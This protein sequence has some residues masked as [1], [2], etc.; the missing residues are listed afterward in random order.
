MNKYLIFY[1][2]ISLL[3]TLITGLS[4]RWAL[5]AAWKSAAVN[6][7]SARSWSFKPVAQKF[8][9]FFGQARSRRPSFRL[10]LTVKMSL[11]F[12][13]MIAVF[14]L[15]A[16]AAAYYAL[17][18]AITDHASKRAVAL[19]TNVGDAAAGQMLAKKTAGLQELVVK[20]ARGGEVAYLVVVDRKGKVLA[21]S[22]EN[23]PDG[24]KTEFAREGLEGLH[25][26]KQ[27][28][29]TFRGAVVYEARVPILEGRIGAVRAAIWK[30]AVDDEIKRAAIPLFSMILIAVV[31]GVAVA[32]CAARRLSQPIL[33]L[34]ES[35]DRISSGSLE[36]APFGVEASGEIGRLA[37]SVERM[38]SSLKAAMTRLGNDQPSSRKA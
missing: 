34:A 5:R 26:T 30:K 14:G 6:D 33:R 3:A 27:M 4:L 1:G 24:P 18:G 21:H 22:L 10:G 11:I 7:V 38:R 32:I 31:V 35:A 19:A 29:T 16:M 23:S 8:A 20:H 12:G 9:L 28:A 17:F 37:R 13:G 2:F 36:T 15:L 25:D